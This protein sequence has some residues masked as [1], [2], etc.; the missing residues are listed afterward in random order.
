[1][2]PGDQPFPPIQSVVHCYYVSRAPRPGHVFNGVFPVGSDDGMIH[3]LRLDPYVQLLPFNLLQTD[4]MVR[5]SL[6]PSASWDT[7]FPIVP[8]P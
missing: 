5:I 2:L 6:N 8:A 1:M 7:V 3:N 4:F